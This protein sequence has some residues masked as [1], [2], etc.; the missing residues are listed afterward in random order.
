[1]TTST[2]WITL[3]HISCYKCGV[4]FGIPANL[5]AE[6]LNNHESFWCPNGHSQH[7]L[8]KTEAQKQRERAEMAEQRAERAEASRRAA[9][10]QAEAAERRRRAAKGQLTKVKNRVANG[11]CPCCNRSFADLAAHMSTKH[12]DYAAPA[13]A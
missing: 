12:P 2:L 9:W 7:Y 4:V 10:D 11:V 1:M 5:N 3:T 13:S 6:L 8:G